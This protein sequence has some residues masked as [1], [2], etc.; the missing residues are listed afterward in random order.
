MNDALAP[1]DQQRYLAVHL[2]FLPIER[3]RRLHARL[4][5]DVANSPMALVSRRRGAVVLAAIDMK[6]AEA[7]L[8]PGMT[9]ADA[10]AQLPDLVVEPE[11][12]PADFALLEWLAESCDR[13]TPSVMA[14]PPDGIL[15][16][17]KGS[18]HLHGNEAG[19]ADDLQRRLARLGL[20]AWLALGATPDAALAMAKYR[21]ASV[22]ALPIAALARSDGLSDAEQLSLRRAGFV[23]TADVA[24]QDRSALAARFGKTLSERLGR[25]LGDVDVRITPRRVPAPIMVEK[26]FA[27]PLIRTEAALQTIETLAIRAAVLMAT[28]EAGGRR[29]EIALFR[30]DGAV[31]RLCVET[32]A[33]LRDAKTLIGLLRDRIEGLADPV[34]PGFGFDLIRLSVPVLSPLAALQLQLE[35]GSLAETQVAALIDRL[36]TRLGR[37]RVR[38]LVSA[39]SHIPEQAAFDL[40][41]ADAG[42]TNWPAAPMAGESPPRPIKLFDPPQPIE[43]VA[44]VPDG[45]PRRFRWR[46]Q[47]HD[48]AFAEGPERIAAEWWRRADGAGLT[49]DYYRVEDSL[50]Q[51]FW[52]F[53]HGLYGTEKASPGWYLHGLFM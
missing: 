21:V 41:F 20:T 3:I 44:G 23:T 6:A 2:P 15:L 10:R 14:A 24:C 27:A 46:Q 29:F 47:Q 22:S 35:G 16:D 32:A 26:R 42:A 5:C 40:P 31:A 9:L 43:V 48:V 36:S 33:P 25:L 50:G 4:E 7:G 8:V 30:S 19:L 17:I 52:L 12:E 37:S 11:D 34:D 51:R 18:A 1:R 53:R 38:R 13:Y 49:R 28:R 45:P 39:D